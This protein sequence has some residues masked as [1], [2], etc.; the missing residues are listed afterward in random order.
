MTADNLSVVGGDT[1]TGTLTM[2]AA[3]TGPGA[4]VNLSASNPVVTVPAFVEL[5]AGS[6]TANFTIATSAVSVNTDV[7]VTANR[8][9]QTASFSIR[10]RPMPVLTDF[11]TNV[12]TVSGGSPVSGFLKVSG[13]APKDGIL[14]NLSSDTTLIEVPLTMKVLYGT[15]VRGFTIKTVPVAA[16]ATGTVTAVAGAVT[17]AVTLTLT[18]GGLHSVKVSPTSVVGGQS[19]V[20][21]VRLTGPAPSGGT[22]VVLST[23]DS[24]AT[25]PPSVTVPAGADKAN[26]PISTSI[27]G[28]KLQVRIIGTLGNTQKAGGL[29]ISPSAII[30]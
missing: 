25:V 10:I 4:R 7:L 18:P 26:F 9:G 23:S 14:C 20:G 11:Y 15:T 27:V 28:K 29:S 24:A 12:T 3:A 19:A 30:D 22:V 16:T 6:N 13:A 1:H 17:K 5:P 2:S 8:Y 21:T